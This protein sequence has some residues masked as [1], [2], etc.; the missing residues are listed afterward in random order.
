M[1]VVLTQLV[2]VGDL[3][4]RDIEVELFGEALPLWVD[5]LMYQVVHARRVS[6]SFA[7]SQR[8]WPPIVGLTGIE[9]IGERSCGHRLRRVLEEVVLYH[10]E[11]L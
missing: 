9:S 2:K 4:T 6:D 1:K 8:P 11:R 7:P 5:N 3:A 10:L